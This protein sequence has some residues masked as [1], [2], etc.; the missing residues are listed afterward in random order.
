MNPKDAIEVHRSNAKGPD[1]SPIGN[2]GP[3][4]AV[5]GWVYVRYELA[6]GPEKLS[7]DAQVQIEAAATDGSTTEIQIT[8]T[9][10]FG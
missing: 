6:D 5:D 9:G 7:Y 1:D 10:T 4:I 8:N 3:D 2:T